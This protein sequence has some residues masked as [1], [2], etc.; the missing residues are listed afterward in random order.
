M[1]DLEIIIYLI[2]AL[3]WLLSRNYRKV[4]QSRPGQTSRPRSIPAKQTTSPVPTTTKT[5][6]HPPVQPKSLVAENKPTPT[7]KRLP[8]EDFTKIETESTAAY[9]KNV[10]SEETPPIAITE[11]PAPAPA[12]TAAEL[13]K[14][15]IYSE[16]LKRRYS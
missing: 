10:L 8:E 4:Q 13:R 15:I 14:A 2:V 12:M 11:K 16:I 9:F 6:L 7:T 5:S 1:N 3:L